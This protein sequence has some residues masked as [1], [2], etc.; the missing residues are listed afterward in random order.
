MIDDYYK[1]RGWSN[2]GV[3]PDDKL[4]SLELEDTISPVKGLQHGTQVY[5][6]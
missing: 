4:R 3:I 5:N 2:E 6:L 1:A